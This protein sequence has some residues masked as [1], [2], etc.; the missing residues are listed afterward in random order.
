MTTIN[1]ISIKASKFRQ[2]E[3]T[4]LR[5]EAIYPEYRFGWDDGKKKNREF[6]NVNSLIKDA[7]VDVN[8]KRI[9]FNEG[10]STKLME[11]V[12]KDWRYVLVEVAEQIGAPFFKLYKKVF[13]IDVT[14]S[15]E[16]T[17]HW[18]WNPELKEEVSLDFESGDKLRIKSFSASKIQDIAKS[19]MLQ[20]GIAKVE[21]TKRDRTTGVE[22]KEMALPYNWEDNILSQMVGKAFE[23]AVDGS[24]LDTKYSFRES[25]FV[26]PTKELTLDDVPF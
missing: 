20:K 18:L 21:V 8:D 10:E 16:I 24:G 7:E 22:K 14:I 6:R 1:P 3:P 26:L 2:L 25:E 12:W 5:I 15:K 9:Q 4:T 23:F 11:K 17:I 13:D 19:M